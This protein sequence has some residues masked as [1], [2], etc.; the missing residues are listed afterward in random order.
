VL[1]QEAFETSLRATARAWQQGELS[2]REA[3]E[4][5]ARAIELYM[6]PLAAA[7]P[8]NVTSDAPP[9]AV[10]VHHPRDPLNADEQIFEQLYGEA[11]SFWASV[12]GMTWKMLD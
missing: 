9:A 4:L 10:H 3:V 7:T 11:C 1:S 5:M 12:R 2:R 8:T 6:T